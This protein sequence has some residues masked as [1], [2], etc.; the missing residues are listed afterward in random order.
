M[1]F[2]LFLNRDSHKIERKLSLIHL[3]PVNNGKSV[4]PKNKLRPLSWSMFMSTEIGTVL[5]CAC[6]QSWRAFVK[7]FL[8]QIIQQYIDTQ[9]KTYAVFKYNFACI[10][11]I[12]ICIYVHT[13]FAYYIFNSFNSTKYFWQSLKI[14]IIHSLLTDIPVY[15]GITAKVLNFSMC[16]YFLTL[17]F[18]ISSY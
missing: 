3:A 17:F 15:P 8:S 4:C 11:Y 14:S 12:C 1:V 18:S 7:A 16:Q 9:R 2:S 5:F 13:H 10:L 6:K